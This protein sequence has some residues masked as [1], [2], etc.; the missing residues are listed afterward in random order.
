MTNRIISNSICQPH[1]ENLEM[2]NEVKSEKIDNQ[3]IVLYAVKDIQ[4][5]FKIGQTQA[6]RLM[7]ASDFPS[8][9]L[10]KRLYISK[11]E[12]EKWIADSK[13]KERSY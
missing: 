8:F 9:R 12:L 11:I 4:T 1:N 10:N 6:Y 5:I 3:S 7:N 13:G 2:V